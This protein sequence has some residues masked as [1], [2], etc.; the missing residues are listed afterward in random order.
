MYMCVCMPNVCSYD[1]GKLAS[2]YCCNNGS[3]QSCHFGKIIEIQSHNMILEA[4]KLL[5]W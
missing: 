3:I 2:V 1:S 4:N 5:Q